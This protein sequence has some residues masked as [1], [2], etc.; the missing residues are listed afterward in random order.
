MSLLTETCQNMQ[1]L[2]NVTTSSVGTDSVT[3]QGGVQLSVGSHGELKLDGPDM[4]HT[5]NNVPYLKLVVNNVPVLSQLVPW[6]PDGSESHVGGSE[7]AVEQHCRH[8]RL[9]ADHE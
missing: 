6:N 8:A 5:V 1:Q 3:L 2:S 9:A 7:A 4:I